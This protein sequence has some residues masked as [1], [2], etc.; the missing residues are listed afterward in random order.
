MFKRRA[1]RQIL[2]SYK[3]P[4]PSGFWVEFPTGPL[5]MAPVTPINVGALQEVVDSLQHR[6]TLGQKARAIL[7]VKELTEGASVPLTHSLPA[8]TEKNS[9]SVTVHGRE[10]T[11]TVACRY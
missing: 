4:P 10:F 7:L 9:P 1:E 5:P 8:M 6:L 2:N 11:D 3:F